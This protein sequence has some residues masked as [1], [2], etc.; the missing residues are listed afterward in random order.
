MDFSVREIFF[1]VYM[2]NKCREGNWKRILGRGNGE[3]WSK[4]GKSD[5]F[6]LKMEGNFQIWIAWRR[7]DKFFECGRRPRNF[8]SN[9]NFYFSIR[10]G[11]NRSFFLCTD[12]HDKKILFPLVNRNFFLFFCNFSS[13]ENFIANWHYTSILFSLSLSLTLSLTHSHK[14]K[15]ITTLIKIEIKINIKY[16]EWRIK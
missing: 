3:Y 4:G 7:F 5:R 2:Y 16:D 13:L 8:F 10:C 9:F 1:Y 12:D 6:V 15:Q 14:G 11:K